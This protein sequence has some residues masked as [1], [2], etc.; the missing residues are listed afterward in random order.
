MGGRWSQ[1][2]NGCTRLYFA[3]LLAASLAEHRMLAWEP[4]F[5]RKLK[6]LLSCVLASGAAAENADVILS[7]GPLYRDPYSP[8]WKPFGSSLYS[9][10]V[11]FYKDMPWTIGLLSF[12]VLGK[13]Q[14]CSVESYQFFHSGNFLRL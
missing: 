11:K 4:L 8:L 7:L 10:V 14:S 3:L 5:L 1:A 2:L 6:A 13:E 9:C 12:M